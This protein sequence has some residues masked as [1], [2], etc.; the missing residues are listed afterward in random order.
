MVRAGGAGDILV[1]VPDCDDGDA[2]NWAS[3]GACVDSDLDTF[4]VGCD[5]YTTRSG[6]DCDDDSV[7]SC[8]TNDCTADVPTET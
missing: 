1:A 5:A 2:D 6:P 7:T 3:C 4:Y 8:D